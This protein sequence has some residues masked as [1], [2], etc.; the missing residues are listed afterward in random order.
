MPG[1]TECK[2]CSV[3]KPKRKPSDHS[4]D[5]VAYGSGQRCGRQDTATDSMWEGWLCREHRPQY[6][7]GD[8]VLAGN[9]IKTMKQKLKGVT[10]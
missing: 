5:Y 6:K 10:T 3:K 9:A 1:T 4:C 2:P 8:A 7:Q